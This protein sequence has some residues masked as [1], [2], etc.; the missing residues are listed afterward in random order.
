[1]TEN[2]AMLC[3]VTDRS[4]FSPAHPPPPPGEGC[5]LESGRGTEVFIL[6]LLTSVEVYKAK[7]KSVEI[8][9][10]SLHNE[11]YIHF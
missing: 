7:E 2:V 4:V 11:N 3:S 10:A 8:S 6:I 5:I 9:K 1:M